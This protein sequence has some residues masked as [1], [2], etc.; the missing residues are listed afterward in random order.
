MN[1]SEIARNCPLLGPAIVVAFALSAM[2]SQS[3][4]QQSNP[5]QVEGQTQVAPAQA[6]STG[7]HDIVVAPIP[8]SNPSIGT[9]L[10]LTGMWL[11]QTDP[12]SPESFSGLGGGYTSNHSWL[13]GAME[14]L[15]FDADLYRLTAGI[16]YGQVNYNFF[17]IGTAS[18]NVSIPLE[19]KVLGGM[20]DFRRKVFS[21]LH[22]GLR[23]TYGDVKTAF[24]ATPG[25]LSP[26][27]SGRQ[28]DLVV[29]GLGLVASWDT[30]DRGFAPTRG[31]FAEF[32]S[33]FA[34]SAFGSDIAFQTYSIA[35]N[36][37]YLLGDPNVLAA[38][39]SLCKV[40]TSAPFFATCAYGASDDLRGYEVGRYRDYN[41][42]SGQAEYRIKLTA[43][44]GA[45]AFAGVGSVANAFGQLFSSTALPAAGVGLRYLAVPSQGVTIS[46]DY[47]WGRAGSSGAYV[48]I[49]D[50][51]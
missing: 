29:S 12:Q 31:T 19:E 7:G 47:A 40:S 21:A 27:I 13:V 25:P 10:A 49:G 16:G 8:I 35:W 18:S 17:G 15:N 46:L 22:V 43:R 30:R 24:G 2:T 20:L 42:I 34:S 11:Y 14:K 44:F 38:R 33:N 51:F 41:M 6:V 23:W 37:Y 5:L 45:V 32:K 1:Q 9:G 39:V 3:F 26:F 48:Y 28:F 50:S 4:G 36:G